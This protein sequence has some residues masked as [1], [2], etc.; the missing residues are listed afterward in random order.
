MQVAEVELLGVTEGCPPGIPKF[1]LQP[2]DTPVLEGSQATFFVTINGPWPLQWMRNGVPIPGATSPSYTTPPVTPQNKGDVYTV[3]MCGDITS[4]PVK[5]TI[6]KPASNK[7][8][9]ISFRGGGANGAPTVM[10]D[11][12]IAGVWLQAHW[13]NAPN[14][15]DGYFPFEEGDPPVTVDLKDS[16]GQV[17][18]ITFQWDTSGTWGSGTGNAS[19]TQRMLNGLN[20]QN[21]ADLPSSFIF[22]NVPDSEH[23]VLVYAVSPPLQFQ[24]VSFKIIGA[25]EK[26]YYMRTMNS[27]EYNAAPGFYS[28][29]STDPSKPEVGNFIRFDKVRPQNG[30][31]TL[32][33]QTLTSGFDRD[34][35]VNALQLVLNAPAVPPLVLTAEPVPTVVQENSTSTL[36]VAATG[37]NLSYQWRKEGRPLPNG[38]SV[39]GANTD[40]LKICPFTP[41]DEGVYSVAVFSSGGSKVSRNAAVRITKCRIT[42]ALVGHWKFDETSGTTAANSAPG[43]QPATVN[44]TAAWQAGQ[45]GN[46]FSFDG[47]TYLVVPSFTLA[48]KAISASAWVNVP[49]GM[50]ADMAI[51]RNA[52][53]E[54]TVSGGAQRIVGQFELGL[55]FDENTWMLRPMAAIG[56]GP[57]VAGAI[58]PSAFPT[59]GW[60]HIAFTADGA[61]LRLYVDGVQVAVEDYLADI[62][63]P[64]IPYISIGARLNLADPA[65]PNSLGPD[66][67][68]PNFMYG[69]VDDVAL[70]T[71][72]LPAATV[73]SIYDTGKLKKPVTDATE[74]CPPMVPCEPTELQLTVSISGNNVTVTWTGGTLQTASSVNGPWTD[75]SAV[76][77]LTEAASNAAKFYRAV[78]K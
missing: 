17:T 41:A 31:I 72:A 67:T 27:D 24:V 14:T 68:Y 4:D 74:L 46:A 6:F 20:G 15:E 38:G 52:Q 8:I 77:P 36:T 53:G 33:T 65:D 34:T 26:T 9:G 43:G 64:D 40:T 22:G 62:N 28:C 44:G 13:N 69:M 16:D 49:D 30:F 58:G 75:S 10:N 19:S 59:G 42:D 73:K 70:W 25:T 18:D 61:Q 54:M 76:S 5:A 21:A 56:I 12:D 60:H 47:A 45:I 32:E 57:N 7:S 63:P 1:L 51:I 39:S 66:L 48:K 50:A 23:S 35:G 78:R 37:E 55:D 3:V 11:D 29:F 71:R 2:V